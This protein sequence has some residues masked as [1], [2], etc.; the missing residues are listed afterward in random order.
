MTVP[1]VID[2]LMRLVSIRSLSRDEGAVADAAAAELAAFGLEVFRQGNN[3]WTQFGDAPR[4]R[5]M[6]NSHLDTVPPGQAWSGDPWTPRRREGRTI[7]L[8]ANDAKGCVS[9]M[10]EAALSLAGDLRIG[11]KLGGTVVLALTAEE[12]TS[13]AGLST[14]L[15]RLAPIDAALVGE[16]TGLV[17]MTAQRG[18][19]ILRLL[20]T[21]RTGHPAHTPP[22]QAENAIHAAAADIA[23]LTAL[24]FGPTHPLLGKCHMHVTQI[25]GGVARNV[26]PDACETWLDVRT[27]PLQPHAALVERLRAC[28]RGRVHVHSDRLVPVETPLDA[29]IV[30]AALRALPGLAP[31]GS[32]AMSDM[33]FL[34]GTPSAKIGPGQPARSHTPDEFVLDEELVAGADAYRRIVRE[35][36][37][38]VRG[39]LEAQS[40]ERA[41]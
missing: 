28:V 15:D 37:S 5:L 20:S 4:P 21:G 7:A 30:L 1:P 9:A 31:T 2:R 27:T 12:E 17:P 25:S 14:I 16:P 35:Y 23:A 18:L 38:V 19:L 3:I 26:I 8:G 40:S 11:K 22:A 36:F 34:A 24:D 41:T 29:A 6:L 33:V 13:G 32:P 39:E 10:M